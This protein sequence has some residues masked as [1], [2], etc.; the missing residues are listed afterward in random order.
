MYVA[1]R[2]PDCIFCKQDISKNT[3]ARS[4]ELDKLIDYL[5]KLKKVIL[6]IEICTHVA[7]RLSS[8]LTYFIFLNICYCHIILYAF[9]DHLHQK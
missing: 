5:V 8:R 9:C 2:G 6:T 1:F 7:L 4:S 3:D